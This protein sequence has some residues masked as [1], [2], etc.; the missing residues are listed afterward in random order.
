M[1][2]ILLKVSPRPE[3]SKVC[4]TCKG[5]GIKDKK[6]ICPDCSGWG[7]QGGVRHTKEAEE[8]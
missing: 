3:G 1:N 7:F 8:E 2:K 4:S 6:Y 5:S